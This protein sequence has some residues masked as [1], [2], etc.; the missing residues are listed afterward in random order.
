MKNNVL[1]L[2]FVPL[3]GACQP[4]T[5]LKSPGEA[6]LISEGRAIVA[7]NCS[8]CHNFEL[9]GDSPREDAPPLRTVLADYNAE[10]LADDFRE[11]IHVGHPDMPDFDFGPKGTDEVVAYLKSIQES[12]EK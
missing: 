7:A 11:S 12:S 6:E 8:S 2:C 3:L 5:D 1:W 10:S 4:Q 9:T